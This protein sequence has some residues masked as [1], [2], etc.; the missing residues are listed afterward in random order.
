MLLWSETGGNVFTQH[1]RTHLLSDDHGQKDTHTHT[2]TRTHTHLYPG[3]CWLHSSGSGSHFLLH[4]I[5]QLPLLQLQ[6][7]RTQFLI[8]EKR[9]K[10]G[11]KPNLNKF[12]SQLVQTSVCVCVQSTDLCGGQDSLQCCPQLAIVCCSQAV[13]LLHLAQQS[14]SFSPT[15]LHTLWQGWCGQRQGQGGHMC[16]RHRKTQWHAEREPSTGLVSW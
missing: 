9:L 2:H 3:S 10:S 15:R 12:L 11:L 8:K 16:Q 13:L 1:I 5:S 7:P 4:E 6:T 14:Q